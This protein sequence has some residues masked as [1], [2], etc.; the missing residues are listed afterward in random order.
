MLRIGSAIPFL[1]VSAVIFLIG[2]KQ[3]GDVMVLGA[4]FLLGALVLLVRDRARQSARPGRVILLDGSNIMHWQGGTPRLEAVREVVDHLTAQ[5][6]TPGVVFDANAGYRLDG[7]YLHH[8]AL[9][10]ALGLPPE[11]VIV[12]NKGEVADALLLR[13]AEDMGARVVSNDRF[14][15]WAA[16]FP[17]LG[18]PGFLIAGR[19][20]GRVLEL[21]LA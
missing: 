12:V 3:S 16:Q 11:R 17:K 9:A 13:A 18:E 21:D 5:G 6:Y 15:D 4:L 8:P 1:A 2:W 20:R 10:R 7:R 19:Y 14:R